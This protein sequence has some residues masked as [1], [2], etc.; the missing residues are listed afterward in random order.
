M[1]SPEHSGVPSRADKEKKGEKKELN[2]CP[3]THRLALGHNG[4][5]VP[6]S[7]PFSHLKYFLT[8]K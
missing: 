2:L 6:L 1:T 7:I 5:G 3:E 4:F 8:Q